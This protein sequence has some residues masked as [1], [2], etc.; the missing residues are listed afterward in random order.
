[1]QRA[2]FKRNLSL[3]KQ[4]S[5]YHSKS[6]DQLDRTIAGVRILRIT[7]GSVRSN[8][9]R[10]LMPHESS[11]PF[12]DTLLTLQ[13]AAKTFSERR[14]VVKRRREA[15]MKNIRDGIEYPTIEAS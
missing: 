7:L 3:L 15:V 2:I 4:V 5:T 14:G 13:Q 6:A 8:F 1:M 12:E 10:S 11:T 9:R